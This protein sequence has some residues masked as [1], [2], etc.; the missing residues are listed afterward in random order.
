MNSR[1]LV[2]AFGR[3]L[4]RVAAVAGIGSASTGSVAAQ[5]PPSQTPVAGPVEWVRYAEGATVTIRSWLEGEDERAARL[6]AYLDA[7]RASPT[8]RT[9]PLVLKLGIAGDG[10]VSRIDF[11][12]FAHEEPNAD[13]RALIVGRRRR[14]AAQGHAAAGSDRN[15]A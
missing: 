14:G 11:T 10:T 12:P 8:A 4:S 13:L 1:V 15:P 9:A 2:S 7:T 6:R 5:T 3:F